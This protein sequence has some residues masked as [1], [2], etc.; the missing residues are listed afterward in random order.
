ME[1][2]IKILEEYIEPRLKNLYNCEFGY[3]V[4]RGKELQA[5]ENLLKRYKEL[6]EINGTLSSAINISV[7][8]N[9]ESIPISVIQNTLDDI[10]RELEAY[11]KLVELGK[12]T[13]CE[14]YDNVANLRTKQVLK[15]ILE[16][17]NK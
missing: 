8:H 12:E 15:E 17:G 10:D 11:K 13:D 7:A 9:K 5:I 4:I 16:K 1:E 14:Y 3:E 6:E 2:D